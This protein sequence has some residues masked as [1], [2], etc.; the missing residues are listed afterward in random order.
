MQPHNIYYTDRTLSLESLLLQIRPQVT[1]EW[2]RF[3]VAIGIDAKILNKYHGRYPADECIVE[4][5]D[6]WLRKSD[7]KPTWRDVA[8]GLRSIGFHQMAENILKVY[9]T[10]KNKLARYQ[11][12]I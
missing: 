2:Y 6:H 3:G 12:L 10:G 1:A 5:L 4:I 7:S 9:T 11:C 8:E